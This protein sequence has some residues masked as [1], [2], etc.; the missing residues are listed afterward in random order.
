VR[1]LPT[2]LITWAIASTI[3]ALWA[4]ATPIA[5][6]PDEPAHVVRAAS[7]VRGDVLLTGRS[8]GEDRVLVPAAVADT[9]LLTCTAF[10]PGRPASCQS[11]V[12]R[13]PPGLAEA[14]TSAGRYNPL[15][16]GLVGWPTLI[17]G[18]PASVYAMRIVSG[19]LVSVFVALTVTVVGG[20]RRRLLP[21]LGV[22]VA[23]TPTWVFLGGMVNPNALEAAATMAAFTAALSLVL[24]PDPRRTTLLAVVLGAA[25]A[26]AANSR[27]L[28]PLWLAV[29]LGGVFVV[30]PLPRVRQA[31]RPASVRIALGVVAAAS[32]AA[33][34]W[35]LVAGALPSPAGT[36]HYPG[37]GTSPF[38]G[39]VATVS[40]TFDYGREMIGLFG[41][42]DTPAPFVVFFLW[43]AF[44]GIGAA[45]AIVLLRR[46]RRLVAVGGVVI[47]VALPAVVAG[48]YVTT[49][50]YIWQGRYALPLFACLTI[51]VACL[52]PPPRLRTRTLVAVVATAWGFAQA[53]SFATALKRYATGYTSSWVAFARDPLWQ[54]PGGSVGIIALSLLVL[55]A[56]AVAAALFACSGIGSAVSGR[57]RNPS[58]STSLS[59]QWAGTESTSMP[60]EGQA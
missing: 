37:V 36:V 56:A 55:T 3:A 29:A 31:L 60:A 18:G 30:A 40:N 8:A 42:L 17:L 57:P 25:G 51:L 9:Q 20:W 53:A 26:V 22:L 21:T 10:A 49:G 14:D 32:V 5:A 15:Y 27:G 4:I 19:V 33:I 52:L 59:G 58:A 39:F 23:L 41:W 28:S 2:F 1:S 54:P 44:I 47:F 48:L 46:R 34:A 16:Y 11:G 45:A 7:V 13:N 43:S 38:A 24:H 12:R 6:S 50:G 35:T